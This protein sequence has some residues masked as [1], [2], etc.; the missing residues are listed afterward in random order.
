[1]PRAAAWLLIAAGANGAAASAAGQTSAAQPGMVSAH[2]PQ[3]PYAWKLPRGFPIPAVPADNPMSE[4]K[5]ALGERLFFEPRISVTGRYSCAS[6]HDPARSFSDGRPVAVGAT[7]EA[8]PHNALA[9]VN[10]AYEVSFGWTKRT[11]RSLEAQMLEPLL[12]SHPVE[13][14]LAGRED[15]VSAQLGADPAYAAAFAAAFPGEAPPVGFDHLVK[16]IAAFERTLISGRSAFDRYVFDGEH[17]ALTPEAKRGMALFFSPR[18]GCS[19]CHSGFNFA[20]NWRDAQG[21]TG[22]PSFASDGAGEVPM[23]VPTLRNIALT[24]PYMHDGRFAT[25]PAVLEHYSS[26]GA[27]SRAGGGD[28]G[29]GHPDRR[30]PR[31]PLTTTE[32]AELIAFLQSLTDES[33][34]RRFASPET[35]APAAGTAPAH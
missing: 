9:L 7:G 8:L 11:V 20:G 12:N 35:G 14:G 21:E 26:V 25:L 30:L 29:L 22:P 18:V 4:A 13:L 2:A 23:R 3:A 10:V 32:R 34:V 24:A 27:S 17:E 6:C 16:A 19:R 15:A 5:V 31:A 1:M 28:G 33:F